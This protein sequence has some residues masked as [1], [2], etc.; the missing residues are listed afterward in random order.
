MCVVVYVAWSGSAYM[1]MCVPRPKQ[2]EAFPFK[3]LSMKINLAVCIICT[4]THLPI[5]PQHCSRK[6]VGVIEN[7]KVEQNDNLK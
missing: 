1:G 3:F 2:A 4:Y 5:L 6:E 7:N